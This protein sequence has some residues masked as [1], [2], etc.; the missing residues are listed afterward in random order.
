MTPHVRLVGIEAGGRSLES[1]RPCGAVRRWCRRR[2]ARHPQSC[3]CRTTTGN[4]LPTHSVSAGLDYPSVGPEHAWLAARGRSEYDWIDDES[5]LSGFEWLARNEGHSCRRSSRLTRS[6]GRGGRST[7][8]PSGAVMLVNISGRG[9]KDVETINGRRSRGLPRRRRNRR[10][11]F[12]A[13]ASEP[14]GPS[15]ALGP[16]RRARRGVRGGE[17]P[18]RWRMSRVA[19]ASRPRLS[20]GSSRTPPPAIRICR[21]RQTSFVRWRVGAPMPS[22]S[23]CRSRIR[24]P[25]ALRFS[26]RPNVRLPPAPRSAARWSLLSQRPRGRARTARSVYVCES[27]AS[28]GHARFPVARRRRRRG[29]R[30][31]ARPADRGVGGDA[32]RTRCVAASIRSFLSVRR[33][34][35]S[36]CSWPV[37]MAVASSTRFRDSAS[38]A[39]ASRLPRRPRLWSHRPRERSPVRSR[40]GSGSRG[41]NTCA[42]S[43]RF[44]DAAIVGSA[45][46][47]VVAD[48]VRNAGNA[49]RARRAVRGVAQGSSRISV[50]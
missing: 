10:V 30:A 49:G 45:I 12:N 1:R 24:S 5:A 50:T 39:R 47:Q 26:G 31:A 21:G 35:T 15:G 33:R 38:P 28:H 13:S 6:S 17:A 18:R 14:R 43:P 19:R 36:G 29:R 46:V 2:P 42:K 27:R 8:L 20:R 16:P 9:D 4:I 48:A 22:K 41:R 34:P 23:G 44:A 3:C 37:D 32:R 7:D 25:T 11:G 40:S